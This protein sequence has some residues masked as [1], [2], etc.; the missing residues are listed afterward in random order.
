MLYKIEKDFFK[1]IGDFYHV[2]SFDLYIHYF[3]NFNN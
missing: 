1:I 2:K 3:W